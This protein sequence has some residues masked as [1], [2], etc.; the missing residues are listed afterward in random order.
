[1]EVSFG[2]AVGH[3][4]R[5]AGNARASPSADVLDQGEWREIYLI[6]KVVVSIVFSKAFSNSSAFFGLS[7]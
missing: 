1:M 2:Q 7:P 6:K 4:R 3:I 5:R